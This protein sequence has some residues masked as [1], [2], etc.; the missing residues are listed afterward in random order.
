MRVCEK[1]CEGNRERGSMVE[2]R[3]REEK[4]YCGVDRE[5]VIAGGG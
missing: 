5:K 1:G 4:S 2:R 3:R